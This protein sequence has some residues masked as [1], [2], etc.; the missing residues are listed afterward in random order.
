MKPQRKEAYHSQPPG[1]WGSFRT[2]LSLLASCRRVVE[3]RSQLPVLARLPN[4]G[5]E[6]EAQAKI[7][8]MG[9]GFIL[10]GKKLLAKIAVIV[11]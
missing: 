6:L 7:V 2:C 5:V 1:S 10:I 9:K 3:G 11:A 4:G 8:L